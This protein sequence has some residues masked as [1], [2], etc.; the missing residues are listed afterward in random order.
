MTT[1]EH[2]S[3]LAEMAA[4]ILLDGPVPM[5]T[6]IDKDSLVRSIY[7]VTLKKLVLED[8]DQLTETELWGCINSSLTQDKLWQEIIASGW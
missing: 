3:Q 7:E 4:G 8:S 2:A 5:G 6:S 1:S